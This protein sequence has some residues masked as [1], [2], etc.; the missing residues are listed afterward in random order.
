M[1]LSN[2][3]T[4]VGVALPI[5]SPSDCR[6][7]AA[8]S[9]KAVCSLADA[10]R[11]RPILCTYLSGG[12]G[13]RP[14]SISLITEAGSP[15]TTDSFRWL[16]KA[17]SRSLKSSAPK[18]FS[19]DPMNMRQAVSVGLFGEKAAVKTTSENTREPRNSRQQ[20]R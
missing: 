12:G 5:L 11:A 9:D 6:S 1:S 3:A 10:L 4:C 20:F 17:L 8:R 15:T 18:L 7:R 14:F 13:R 19:V 16:K 2:A